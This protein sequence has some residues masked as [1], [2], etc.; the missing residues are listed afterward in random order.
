MNI[1]N[2]EVKATR[3]WMKITQLFLSPSSSAG[4]LFSKFTETNLFQKHLLSACC[5]VHAFI[6]TLT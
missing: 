2:Y 1:L 5:M 3:T 6:K 4:K